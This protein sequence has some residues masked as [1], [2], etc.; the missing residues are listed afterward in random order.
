MA[1][2]KFARNQSNE[3]TEM[4]L[5][6]DDIVTMNSSGATNLVIKT[7]KVV[8]QDATNP[9]VLIYTLQVAGTGGVTLTRPTIVQKVIDTIEKAGL[10]GPTPTVPDMEVQLVTISGDTL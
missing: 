5:N 2:I 9:E 6:I 3:A 8:L 10:S 7:G 4:L 1:Y